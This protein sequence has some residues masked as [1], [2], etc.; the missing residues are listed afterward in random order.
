M[1]KIEIL[2]NEE[3]SLFDNPPKFILSEQNIYFTLPDEVA[4]WAKNIASPISLVGFTLLWG[5]AKS[6]Y[7]F[8]HPSQFLYSD[9]M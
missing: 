8:F 2:D 9:I 4:N 7:R 6:R 5:Y 3:R 1:R